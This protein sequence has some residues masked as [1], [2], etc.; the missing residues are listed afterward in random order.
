M[1]GIITNRSVTNTFVRSTYVFSWFASRSINFLCGSLGSARS[2][3]CI[4]IG[5]PIATVVY[6]VIVIV[7]ILLLVQNLGLLGAGPIL[8]VR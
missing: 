5:D 6:V 4:G 1:V 3:G 2:Y 8:R 7:A